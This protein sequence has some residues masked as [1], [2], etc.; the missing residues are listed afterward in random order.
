MFVF[1]DTNIFVADP[2][3]RG[4]KYRVLLDYLSKTQGRLVVLEAVHLEFR[5]VLRRK[6]RA[7]VSALQRAGDEARA[8]GLGGLL[9]NPA[10][11]ETVEAALAEWDTHISRQFKRSEIKQVPLDPAI[12]RD[13]FVR[14]TE[15]VPPA[16]DD[17]KESRDV[18]IWL[19]LV[20]A[21][22]SLQG[23]DAAFISNNTK[24]FAD[25]AGTDLRTELRADLAGHRGK[26]RYYKH[27]E[28][29]NRE[30]AAPIAHITK[31]WIAAR[32]APYRVPELIEDYLSG[33]TEPRHFRIVDSDYRAEYQ[34]YNVAGT[35]SLTRC[36]A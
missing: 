16:T 32:I 7:A 4:Q 2:W 27:L 20:R 3:L 24:H 28:E 34:A 13:V 30:H 11:T 9:E 21:L 26:V 19:S 18:I 10:G 31:D 29:F 1:L 15:R 8:L 35:A 36:C 22:A 12:L 6:L 23:N 5:S 25:A 17:G 14:T 33:H